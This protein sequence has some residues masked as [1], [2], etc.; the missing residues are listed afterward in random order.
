MPGLVPT[1][2]PG[3]LS[4]ALLAN[5]RDD[6]EAMLISLSTNCRSFGLSISCA[7][8][9]VM[10][11][12]PSN[13]CTQRAPIYLSS[14]QPPI[15]S[16]SSFEYLGSIVQADC[17]SDLEVNSRICKASRAFGSLSRILWFQKKIQTRTK[18]R[19]LSSVIIP[20]LLYG[21]ECSVLLE[22]Q[23]HRLQ[24]F[25]MRCLRI[26]LGISIWDLKRNTTIRK[27]GHQQRLS[28]MLSARRLCLL[29]HISRMSDL[30][31]PNQLLVCAPIGGVR[32]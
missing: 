7:K 12:L 5:S 29:G 30:R 10:A 17:G 32:S 24:S 2:N 28:S 31:L 11:V 20:T 27:L 9:K 3:G 6:L 23:V 8:T 16:V 18:L 25:V 22:P 19:I 4:L 15:E 13:T 21:T 1:S 14:N 26:I